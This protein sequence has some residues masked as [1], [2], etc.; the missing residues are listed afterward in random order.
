MTPTVEREK[1][2]S[3]RIFLAAC[4]RDF[5][6][7]LKSFSRLPPDHRA[8][9]EKWIK[10]INA[11]LRI[12]RDGPLPGEQFPAMLQEKMRLLNG[13]FPSLEDMGREPRI[14]RGGLRAT[15]ARL[16]ELETALAGAGASTGRQCV[17]PS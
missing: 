3:W 8:H 1:L 12:V 9:V 16:V 5:Q 15:E 7:C 13:K 4:E 2:L 6:S 10:E 14:E 17:T 11:A